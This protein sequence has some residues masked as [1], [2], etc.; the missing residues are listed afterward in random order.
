[1]STLTLVTGALGKFRLRADKPNKAVYI[2]REQKGGFQKGGFGGCSPGTKTGT[3]VHSDVPPER[4]TGTRVHFAKTTLLRTALLSPGDNVHSNHL[5]TNLSCCTFQLELTIY[6][7]ET[8]HSILHPGML[9]FDVHK[10]KKNC[11]FLDIDFLVPALAHLCPS[12]KVCLVEPR[13]RLSNSRVNSGTDPETPRRRSQS[14]FRISRFRTVG[15]P[16]GNKSRFPP[17]NRF[18]IVFP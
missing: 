5:D 3:R 17:Q 16:H 9:Q 11:C 10:R 18:R 13:V 4:K 12:E 14:K 1:M 15:D 2:P 6:R 8:M 7:P